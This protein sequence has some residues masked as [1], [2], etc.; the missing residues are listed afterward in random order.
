MGPGGVVCGEK[1][2]YKKSRETVPL[3]KSGNQA[4]LETS[5]LG[6]FCFYVIFCLKN[7]SVHVFPEIKIVKAIFMQAKTFHK[8]YSHTVPT[9]RRHDDFHDFQ[10]FLQKLNLFLCGTIQECLHIFD[11]Y[12][13]N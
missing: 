10:S 3:K 9:K 13:K 7:S 5:I 4:P 2:E 6:L 12:C 8:N 11:L 1:T